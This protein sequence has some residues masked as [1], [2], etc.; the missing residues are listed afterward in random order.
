ME[1]SY[2]T[3]PELLSE[4]NND[5]ALSE[6][7]YMFGNPDV[8]VKIN[9][10]DSNTI[11]FPADSVCSTDDND[12]CGGN[13]HNENDVYAEVEIT[14]DYVNSIKKAWKTIFKG[15]KKK[16]G[17]EVSCVHSDDTPSFETS[18][19]SEYNYRN[20]YVKIYDDGVWL[21]LPSKYCSTVWEID[22]QIAFC[23]RLLK[24]LAKR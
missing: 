10:N 15:S 2:I 5:K 13:D 20:E 9:S 3:I 21:V 24:L 18:D 7:A 23:D 16:F 22:L 4:F 12:C 11:G 14:K 1:T 8:K 19:E 17:V 6:E